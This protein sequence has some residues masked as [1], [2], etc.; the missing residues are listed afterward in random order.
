[1]FKRLLKQWNCWHE[2]KE[3]ETWHSIMSTE[4]GNK[5]EVS[6]TLLYC[7]K[8]DKKKTVM[9]EEYK[10]KKA[11]EEKINNI[12]KSYEKATKQLDK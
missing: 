10:K 7:P 5:I 2:F 4:W 1:M 6:L 12:K 3:V 9:T 8:C 11:V